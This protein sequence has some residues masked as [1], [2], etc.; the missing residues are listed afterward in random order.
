MLKLEIFT[1]NIY[2][3]INILVLHEATDNSSGKQQ[4]NQSGWEERLENKNALVNRALKSF[5]VFLGYREN[6]VHSQGGNMLKKYL[7]RL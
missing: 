5:H 1:E 7:Q 6:Y 3:E 4:T 2:K